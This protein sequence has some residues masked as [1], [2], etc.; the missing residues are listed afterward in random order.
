MHVLTGPNSLFPA[1]HLILY[2]LA[3]LFGAANYILLQNTMQLVNDNCVL[4]PRELEFHVIARPNFTDEVETNI[5]YTMIGDGSSLE[6]ESIQ[7]TDGESAQKNVTKREIPDSETIEGIE[8]T[9]DA[10]NVTVIT[11][12]CHKVGYAILISAREYKWNCVEK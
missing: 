3:A 10:V 11:G 7:S 9:M 8:T 4:Y 6:N 5:N 12:E 2:T 1:W